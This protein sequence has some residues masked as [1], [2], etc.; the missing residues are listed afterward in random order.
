MSDPVAIVGIGCRFPGATSSEHYWDLLINSRDAISEVPKNRWN[1]DDFYDESPGTPG[2]MNTRW[3]GFLDSIDRF[4][5]DFFGISHREAERMDPQ[6]R[7]AIEVAHEAL[8]DAGIT[9]AS[10]SGTTAGVYMG[11]SAFDHGAALHT[12]GHTPG[13]YDGTG[14]ALSIVANRISYCLN[15]RGPSM[16]VDTACSSSLVAVHLACES[17]RRGESEVALAGGVNVISSPGVAIIFSQAGLMAPDGR[18]KTFDHRANGY[19]RS[20]GVGVVVLKSLAKAQADGDRIYGVV[21]GGAINHDGKTNGLTAPSRIAQIA[22][23]KSAYRAVDIDPTTVDF[24]EAHGTGTAVGD[25]I[26]VAALAEVLGG[27]R[28]AGHELRIGSAKTNVGH[29]EAAAGI[30]G[31]IKVAL[32]LHNRMLPPTAHFEA[33]NPL[34]GLDHIPL[35]VQRALDPWPQSG[36]RPLAGVS[37]FGFGGTN[38]H[39]I[40]AGAPVGASTEPLS[41]NIAPALIPISA[42]SAAQLRHQTKA[43]AALAQRH[44]TEPGWLASVAAAAAVRSTHHRHRLAII[45]DSAAEL[46][47]YA[48]AFG[49]GENCKWVAGPAEKAR[50]TPR[51]A[52]MF[53]GQGSQWLGMGRALAQTVP[54]FREAIRRC[55]AAIS[56]VIGRSLWSDE[57]GLL[58]TETADI[59]PALFAIQ[60]ALAQTWMAWGIRPA[61]VIGHSMGEVAAAYV[62]GALSLQDAARIVCM[63]SALADEIA[64]SGGLALLE[65]ESDRAQALLQGRENALSIAAINGPRSTVVSGT[66]D[67]IEDLLAEA[68]RRQIFARRI[69]VEFAAHSPQIE[70]LLPRLRGMLDDIMPRDAAIPFYSTVSGE[71]VLGTDLGPDYWARNFRETVLFGPTSQR[72]FADGHTV[73]VELSPHPVLT[74]SLSEVFH[75]SG[76]SAT[77]LSSLSRD[78]NEVTALLRSLGT[79]Y[80]LGAPIDWSVL[81]PGEV[82][83]RSLP[84][85][86]WNHQEFPAIRIAHHAQS[87]PPDAAPRQRGSLLGH[88]IPIGIDQTLKVWPLPFDVTTRPE[89]AG[90]QVDELAVV[91]AAYWLAAAVEAA[92][93]SAIRSVTLHDI[94]LSVPFCPGNRSDGQLQLSVTGGPASERRFAVVSAAASP[95][96]IMHATGTMTLDQPGTGGADSLA[97]VRQRCS[98]DLAVEQLYSGLESVGL[99]YGSAFRGLTDLRIGDNEALARF[100]RPRELTDTGA[101]LHPALLD[102]CLHTVGATMARSE[103]QGRSLPLPIAID[104]LWAAI[105]RPHVT[106]GWCHAR[107]HRIG[108]RELTADVTVWD[109]TG[110]VVCRINGLTVRLTVPQRTVTDGSLYQLDWEPLTLADEPADTGTWVVIG[111]D[112]AVRLVRRGLAA[113]GDRC[114]EVVV[115]R[116]NVCRAARL[117]LSM[118]RAVDTVLASA[119]QETDEL[120]GVIDLRA[121]IP[122]PVAPT[123]GTLQAIPL[124]A[125]RVAQSMVRM[126]LASSSRLWLVTSGTQ[127]CTA[128]PQDTLPAGATLWGLGRVVAT[129]LPALGCSLVDAGSVSL[130]PDWRLDEPDLDRLIELFRAPNGPSQAV[131]RDG[132]VLEPRLTRSLGVGASAPLVMRPDATYLVTGGLGALG[133]LVA[134]WLIN[135]GARH[136]VLAG[137]GGATPEATA[138]VATLQRAGVQVRIA[139]LDVGDAD[140]VDALIAAIEATPQPLAGVFH[141]AGVLADAVVTAVGESELDVTLS[142]KAWGAWHL[143]RATLTLP[144]DMFVLFSSLAGLVGSPG[145]AAYAAANTFLDA[146]AEQ[147]MTLGLPATSVAW[148]T[149]AGDN[150]AGAG[151]ERLAARGFPPLRPH[152]GV[153]LLEQAVASRRSAVVAAAFEPETLRQT[154]SGLPDTTRRMLE[155]VVGGA[156]QGD[157]WVRG[158]AREA[159]LAHAS[160]DLRREEARRQIINQV[161]EV[162]GTTP[163]RIDPQIPFQESGLDSLTAIELRN[164]L[165]TVF[166]AQLSAALFFACPTVETF[167]DELCDRITADS[168]TSPGQVRSALTD[169]VP[170]VPPKVSESEVPEDLSGLT[171][172]ELAEMVARELQL[173]REME[174]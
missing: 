55:D 16:T 28:L 50:R 111:T 27:D 132:A 61:A 130:G 115:D 169:H 53:P 23:L 8:D 82:R 26:E 70:P 67:A 106:E 2:K 65:L 116:E 14:A 85:H 138:A 167:A 45:A 62:S 89:L 57:E 137:R 95:S 29:L 104:Q 30:A 87:G 21:L 101:L 64:G 102:A 46:A 129:E 37:S 40:V 66:V 12:T 78:E 42:P 83:H 124:H 142:G 20:E 84:K 11:V 158:S 4:D 110:A 96:P 155:V 114:I 80:T 109:E 141:A 154:M 5:A 94:D 108:S 90:H 120:R 51:I 121:L 72:L 98:Q 13:V 25:P 39:L 112:N 166:D 117:D 92:T 74:H 24:V 54:A 159:V 79:L 38:A 76:R 152:I 131:I 59:Q 6:Q 52:F 161:A 17:V 99:H 156:G 15:L 144:L 68:Q 146:L 18:C 123:G 127:S 49:N 149:W 165:E 48:E 128:I 140:Q 69:A 9:A 33:P 77:V 88:R 160:V 145:Q 134:D 118:P 133:L 43:W 41:A 153:E 86:E 147:R 113:R 151:I 63:R 71:P 103:A 31:L 173:I 126:G 162:L 105:D 36:G 172:D 107:L 168:T 163:N 97:N 119:L 19:V 58:A 164:R 32:S 56:A 75:G 47:S 44:T 125:L 170:A 7:L 91:P 139:R 122:A 35:V 22:L 136:L 150:L 3:G 148:G 10:L 100:E 81:H 174:A 1:L 60:V 93:E 34:L 143:H 135:C 73:F 171:E 157:R